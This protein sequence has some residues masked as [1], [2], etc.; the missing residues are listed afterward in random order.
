MIWLA[1]A[2]SLF[3]LALTLINALTIGRPKKSENII[4]SAVAVL[5]PMRNEESSVRHCLASALGQE[6]LSR[7]KVLVLDDLSTDKTGDLLLQEVEKD[8]KNIL[9]IIEGGALPNGWL[10]KNYACHQLAQHCESE[11][12]VF[13]DADV[14]LTPAAISSS[15]SMMEEMKWDFIS[16]YPRQ[17]VGSWLERLLQ[18]LLQW[19]WFA[20]VPLRIAERFKISSMAVANGQFFI[21]RAA[22]YKKVGGHESIKS[23]IL[24]DIEL[25]RSLLRAGSSGGV[26]D[27]SRLAYCRMYSNTADVKNGYTKSLWKAFGNPLGSVLVA[28]LLAISGIL[29]LVAG[30]LGSPLGWFAYFVIVLSRLVAAVKTRS[31]WQSALLHPISI[32]ALLTLLALSWIGK[33]RG[34]LQWRGRKV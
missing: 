3:F 20:T 24:D 4:T 30:I 29:P 19:S 33:S 32:A 10:G 12:L 11:Y 21:L 28:L 17:I 26:V 5:I 9:E 8:N 13:L 25:A 2:V 27:G 14:R 31:Y 23:E 7:V 34:T 22:S 18:P 6:N 1:S 15:I 16:P